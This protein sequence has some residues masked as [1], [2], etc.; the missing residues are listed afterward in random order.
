MINSVPDVH[1]KKYTGFV[2][3]LFHVR[4]PLV[5]CF[6][7]PVRCV[8]GASTIYWEK[9]FDARE[10]QG[11]IASNELLIHVKTEKYDVKL[12]M[13]WTVAEDFT[14]VVRSVYKFCSIVVVSMSPKK[15]YI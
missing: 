6:V 4:V 14:C 13:M 3:N 9:R 12:L 1:L 7:T 11:S 15:V 2:I 10:K 8:R 5:K